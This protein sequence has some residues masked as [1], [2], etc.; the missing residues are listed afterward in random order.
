[1][2]ADHNLWPSID[3]AV[4]NAVNLRTGDGEDILHTLGFQLLNE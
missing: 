1:M 3:Q 4:E 2:P